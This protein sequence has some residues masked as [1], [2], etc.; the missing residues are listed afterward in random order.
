MVIV[1]LISFIRLW[2]L[3]LCSSPLFLTDSSHVFIIPNEIP[4]REIVT[5]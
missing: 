2:L 3:Q 1:W 4:F 5:I